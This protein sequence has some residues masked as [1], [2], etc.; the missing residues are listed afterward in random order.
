[1]LAACASHPA[2]PQPGTAPASV[3][4]APPAGPAP[5][6][7]ARLAA[8]GVV[9]LDLA[10]RDLTVKPGDDFYRYANGGWFD[11]FSIPDERAS[12][13]PFYELD[14]LSRRR[15]REII[16]QAAAAHA[17]P[18]TAQQ[19]IGDF[20]A[21]YMD[22]EAIEAKGLEPARPTLERIAG[23]SRQEL[24]FLF[25]MPGLPSLFNLDIT[26]DYH[27]PEHYAV[28]IS[29]ASLGLPDRDYYL[30]KD[31]HLKALRAK[32]LAY[33]AEMF[34]LLGDDRWHAEHRARDVLAFETEAARVQWPIE[35]RREVDQNWNPRTKAQ[36]LEYAPGFPW[37]SFLEGIGLGS[38]QE[39]VLGETTAVRD[40]ASLFARTPLPTLRDWL[41]FQYLSIYAEFLPQRFDAA[42]FGFYGHAL[43]G[44][45]A[46]L[47]R[48]KR[49]VQ[50][51]NEAFGDAVGREY[52]KLYFPPS[53]RA[54]MQ[55]LVADLLAA[56]DARI[57][58]LDWMTPATKVR[59]HQKLAALTTKIG[60]PDKWK[61]YAALTV[62]RDDLMGNVTRAVQWQWDYRRAHLNHPV[63]HG[64]WQMSPQD[65]NAYYDGSN[66]EIVLPA[67]LLQPPFFEPRA[68]A[69]VNYGA[70]GAIIGHEIS[71]GF[72]DQGR[73]FGPHGALED[74]WT[75]QD[76]QAFQARTARLEQQFAGFEVLPGVHVNGAN[77]V[78]EN[79]GDLGGLNMAH[80][81]YRLS[82][83][84][85]SAPLVEG[86]SG[87]QRFFLAWAQ[88]WREKD[89]DGFLR[90]MVMS[91]THSPAT[92]RVN[93]P[94]PNIDAWYE[95]F[96]VQPGDK[97]YLAPEER[98][99]VW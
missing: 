39:L 74:W 59:A 80:E 63:D 22:Q 34:E 37:Q 60:Y 53:S 82:L 33:I 6:A 52:V 88:A 48:W 35:R 17:A 32:Y 62:H 18:G 79:L 75:P 69:A 90:E 87:E 36:L 64:E 98:V 68:D 72:D 67:G 19:Q 20:Y 54:Q 96:H 11:Q 1:V 47:E 99:R 15:V 49:A 84:G 25:G 97:L 65:I 4:V 10:G 14:D 89:R 73:K 5:A 44:Q 28:F 46:Q 45:P 41:T 83:K 38:R 95:A 81:A 94:L 26:P 43:R 71:H 27:D 61:D 58:A 55:Q 23:A 12:Y 3:A 50:Q 56:L 42:H 70:I 77:T 40:L 78:G 92:V 31:P 91:D 29:E 57:E 86:L 21:S 51:V 30:K 24:A 93:G 16:E 9:G 85:Q 13:G 66:N 7:A 76:V 2:A 8:S